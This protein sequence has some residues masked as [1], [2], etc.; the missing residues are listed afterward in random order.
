MATKKVQETMNIAHVLVPKH[1]LLSSEDANKVLEEYNITVTE[2]PKIKISDPAI[3]D[4]NAKVGDIIKI[5]R[6]SMSSGESVFYRTVI[7]D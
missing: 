6:D 7:G 3:K 2:L 5:T 1:E 4:K